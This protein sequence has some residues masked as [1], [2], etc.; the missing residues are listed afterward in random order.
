MAAR[1]ISRLS[2]DVD[3]EQ[4]NFVR[5]FAL[6]NEITVSVVIRALLH[7]LQTDPAFANR[8][9]DLIFSVP[10]EEVE[11]SSNGDDQMVTDENGIIQNTPIEVSPEHLRGSVLYD[12]T[13]R[14]IIIR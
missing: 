11:G 2:L 1:K 13:G 6:H 10:E 7:A 3:A 12:S 5:L 4:K 8:I 14:K 9:I